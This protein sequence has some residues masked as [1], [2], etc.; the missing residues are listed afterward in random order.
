[1]APPPQPVCNFEV[2]AFPTAVPNPVP[3]LLNPVTPTQ[4]L[5]EHQD[6]PNSYA[7]KSLI[8]S[9]K[10]LARLIFK[11]KVKNYKPTQS[12]TLF[13]FSSSNTHLKSKTLI[14]SKLKNI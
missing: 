5:V 14:T 8:L 1:M 12:H 6:P 9:P 11:I 13:M 10:L 3:I 7:T 2:L 4:V